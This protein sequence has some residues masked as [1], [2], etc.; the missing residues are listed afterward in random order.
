MD[1]AMKLLP[2][3]RFKYISHS[4]KLK[5]CEPNLQSR[6]VG[7]HPNQFLMALL[8]PL[9]H[10]PDI[11]I[12]KKSWICRLTWNFYNFWK[13]NLPGWTLFLS[14]FFHSAELSSGSSMWLL[15]KGFLLYYWAVLHWI[16]IP[17]SVFPFTCQWTMKGSS[18]LT[19]IN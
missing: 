2:Q 10:C 12:S 5:I 1:A 19:I 8:I 14:N 16:D 4:S 6:T 15:M 3:S 13:C 11:F 9:S 17:Q 7:R 18:F